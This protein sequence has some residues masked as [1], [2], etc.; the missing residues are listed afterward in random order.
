[1]AL[2]R[3]KPC[4]LDLTDIFEHWKP[5]SL[6]RIQRDITDYMAQDQ[7]E[8]LEATHMLPPLKIESKPPMKFII[9]PSP[10]SDCYTYS[11]EFGYLEDVKASC[12]KLSRLLASQIYRAKYTPDCEPKCS[13]AHLEHQEGAWDATKTGPGEDLEFWSKMWEEEMEALA[14]KAKGWGS[15]LRYVCSV[16]YV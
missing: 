6:K 4:K 8:R 16:E 12:L 9:P 10:I 7:S 5:E 15:D 2:L 14:R 13:D 11:W 3:S 1:M